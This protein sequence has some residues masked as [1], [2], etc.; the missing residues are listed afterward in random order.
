M[1][2]N[3]KVKANTPIGVKEGIISF[4]INGKS[5]SGNIQCMGHKVNFSGGKFENDAFEFSGVV[6]KFIYKVPYTAKGSIKNNNL[7]AIADTKYGTI[8]IK[9]IEN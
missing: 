5:L 7:I 3:F 4:S 6:K 9:S 8:S 1:I 2:K